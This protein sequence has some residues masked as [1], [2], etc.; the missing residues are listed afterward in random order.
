L[1]FGIGEK[2]PPLP[3]PCN[4]IENQNTSWRTKILTKK[5]NET[6]LSLIAMKCDL[7]T[8][9]KKEICKYQ[10]ENYTQ[11]LNICEGINLLALCNVYN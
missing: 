5:N 2:L 8:Y 10:I 6:N 11:I 4:L 1:C 9:Q 3:I 7:E